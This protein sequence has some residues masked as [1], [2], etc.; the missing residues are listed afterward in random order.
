[1]G[2]MN[3]PTKLATRTAVAANGLRRA[4]GKTVV[5]D[6]VDL[7]IGEGEVFALLGPNGAGKT[8]TIRIL[9]TL[10]AADA[11]TA[12]VLGH[13]LHGKAPRGARGHRGHRGHRGGAAG[14]LPAAGLGRGLVRGGRHRRGVLLR[15]GLAG[16]SPGKLAGTALSVADD[17]VV[18]AG[19]AGKLAATMPKPDMVDLRSD[20]PRSAL[21][22][23]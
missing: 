2:G 17:V 7:S 12:S 3:A 4:Y 15:T 1:M 10:I 22:R 16:A 11:G 20:W 21:L 13:D 19:P 5:L 9:S 18:A 6:G 23:C 14:R 8:T